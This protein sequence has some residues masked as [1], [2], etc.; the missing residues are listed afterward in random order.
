MLTPSYSVT[1]RFEAATTQ[2]LRA[3]RSRLPITTPP[4]QTPKIVSTGIVE[5]RPTPPLSDYSRRRCATVSC[6]SSSTQPIA[7]TGDD[8][9]F[10]RVLAYGPDPLLADRPRAGTA[11]AMLTVPEPPLPIDPETV[12]VVFAGRTPTR[13]GSTR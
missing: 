1:A 5:S 10:G 4:A 7:D 12:R 8:C 11:G 9:Y 2:T 13:P 3:A 6:G